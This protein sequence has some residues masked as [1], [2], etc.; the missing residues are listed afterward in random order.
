MQQKVHSPP[1]CSPFNGWASPRVRRS[2][3][4]RIGRH[5]RNRAGTRT[6]RRRRSK[7]QVPCHRGHKGTASNQSPVI[8]DQLTAKGN[9]H[10]FLPRMTL[11]TRMLKATAFPSHRFTCSPDQPLTC[12]VC[13]QSHTATVLRFSQCPSSACGLA[14]FQTLSGLTV[15]PGAVSSRTANWDHAPHAG[16]TRHIR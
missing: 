2:A 15:R 14:V 13:D 3:L 5:A 9:G 6:T 4:R 16:A 8:S 10:G 11:I 12:S 7:P 1:V